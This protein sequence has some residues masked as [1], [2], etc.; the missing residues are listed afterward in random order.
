MVF[1]EHA[2]VQLELVCGSTELE[3]LT[4]GLA[5]REVKASTIGYNEFYF[6]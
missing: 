6:F 5:G 4:A 2:V 3:V 1:G